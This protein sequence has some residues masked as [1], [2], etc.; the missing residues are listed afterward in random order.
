MSGCFLFFRCLCG[1]DTICRNCFRYKAFK[2]LPFSCKYDCEIAKHEIKEFMS[3]H[4]HGNGS[5]AKSRIQHTK[6]TCFSSIEGG[7]EEEGINKK[8]LRFISM[9]ERFIVVRF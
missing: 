2:K 6:S 7:G 4:S 5:N 8:L 1:G 9:H 3:L